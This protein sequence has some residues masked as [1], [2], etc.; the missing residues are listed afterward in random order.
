MRTVFCAHLRPLNDVPSDCLSELRD[1]TAD[2]DAREFSQ[3]DLK[4]APKQRGLWWDDQIRNVKYKGGHSR[5][6]I[7]NS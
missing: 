7:G 3:A 5:L 1:W 6:S 4:C 2:L